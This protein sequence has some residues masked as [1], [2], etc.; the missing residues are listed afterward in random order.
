VFGSHDS[1][2]AN[3]DQGDGTTFLDVIWARAPFDSHAR[4]LKAVTS[5]SANLGQPGSAH[6]GGAG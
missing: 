5:T 1:G 3:R 6:P 2:V 4:F